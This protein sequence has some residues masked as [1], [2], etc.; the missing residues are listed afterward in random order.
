MSAHRQTDG[1]KKASHDIS[2]VHSVHLADI[3]R[4]FGCLIFA[5]RFMQNPHYTC[6]LCS[7]STVQK[8]TIQCLISTT[9]VMPEQNTAS[10][11]NYTYLQNNT[12]IGQNL[13]NIRVK[14]WT[15]LGSLPR[16]KGRWVFC[17][18]AVGLC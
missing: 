7:Y 13:T 15:I 3:I 5:T 9:S 2:P 10:L 6:H 18:V 16:K 4:R 14:L 17:T 11:L 1:R 8:Q 12:E